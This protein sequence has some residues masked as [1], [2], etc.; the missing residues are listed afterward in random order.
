M[1]DF[2]NDIEKYLRGELTPAEMNALERKALNDPFLAEALEGAQLAGVENFHA[3][4][5]SLE[6]S[7]QDRLHS[8]S[9]KVVSLWVWPMRIAAGLLLLAVSTFAIIT[10]FDKDEVTEIA[11]VNE[12][13]APASNSTTT[14]SISTEAD[15]DSNRNK[16]DHKE[17]LSLAKPQEAKPSSVPSRVPSVAEQPNQQRET[18]VSGESS[19]SEPRDNRLAYHPQ[20]SE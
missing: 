20:P 3:D 8:T 18:E 6:A 12:N 17:L 19:E 16:V 11:Q 4:M 2:K 10:L 14:D 9:G 15:E 13:A 1:R 5:K 7:L